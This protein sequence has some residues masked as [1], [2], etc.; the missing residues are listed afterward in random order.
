MLKNP[1]IKAKHGFRGPVASGRFESSYNSDVSMHALT[2]FLDLVLFLDHA[3]VMAWRRLATGVRR[4]EIYIYIYIYL[5]LCPVL[6]GIVSYRAM[7]HVGGGGDL[8]LVRVL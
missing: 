5:K 2:H 3:K 1:A 6:N 7:Q 4:A 8:V